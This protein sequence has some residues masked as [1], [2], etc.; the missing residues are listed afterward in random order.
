MDIQ[1]FKSQLPVLLK[2]KTTA[3][4][5]AKH[6]VGKSSIIEQFAKDNGHFCVVQNLGT[7]ETGDVQGLLD[8]K[9]GISTFLP[10]KFVAELNNFARKNPTK[11]AICFLDEINHIHKDMQ[12][13]LFGALLGNRIGDV[14]M[15]DNVRYVAAM[16]PPTKDYPG[17]F[18]F[19]NLALVDRFCHIEL[20]PTTAEW[21]QYAKAQNIASDLIDFFIASP[22]FLSPV[23][24]ESY[25]VHKNI[26]GSPR[27]AILAARLEA[28]GAN[29]E[30]LEGVIGTAALQSYQAWKKKKAEDSLK[31]TD[32]IGRKSLNK[33]TVDTLK[34]WAAEEE[35]GKINSLCESLKAH[36]L[37]MEPG[38]GTQEDANRLQEMLEL[39]PID[40]AYEM[41]LT[42]ARDI[43]SINMKF[44]SS[45]HPKAMKFWE[46]ALKA[47]KVVPN[48]K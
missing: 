10:P 24:A 2:N 46:A 43:Q 18:D 20:M 25:N 16:N 1:T 27:S 47:G 5:V 39:M 11:Y 44:D 48:V 12:S 30:V 19:R 21:S 9:D 29:E 14:Q 17:V 3:L 45:V 4:L 8:I 33:K 31:I 41:V 28:D 32:I 35:Y 38:T 37:A 36:F 6:G 15:E 23:S 13:V 22:N 42:L 40:K 34:K 26:K 7:K